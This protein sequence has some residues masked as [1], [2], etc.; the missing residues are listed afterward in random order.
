MVW[1][2]RKENKICRILLFAFP[3]QL[4]NA[5]IW[6]ISTFSETMGKASRKKSNKPTESN[7]HKVELGIQGERKSD[8]F[9]ICRNL[10]LYVYMGPGQITVILSC[11]F[12]NE[13]RP[14]CT[15][16]SP[17]HRTT[18][19]QCNYE[20]FAFGSGYFTADSVIRYFHGRN[21]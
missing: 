17:S 20:H 6:M 1:N 9:A 18:I 4:D 16:F 15:T 10:L 14:F 19:S 7:I 12:D 2:F 3:S 13:S 11:F 5:I 8:M 21:C